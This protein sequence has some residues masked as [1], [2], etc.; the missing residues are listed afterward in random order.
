MYT[1]SI[2]D[3]DFKVQECRAMYRLACKLKANYVQRYLIVH[4]LLPNLCLS[5]CLFILDEAFSKISLPSIDESVRT[6]YEL[7]K[8]FCARRFHLLISHYEEVVKSL[9]PNLLK[10]LISKSLYFITGEKDLNRYMNLL[11]SR[12]VA[13]DMFHFCVQVSKQFKDAVSCHYQEVDLTE[14]LHAI[15]GQPVKFG[16][17]DGRKKVIGSPQVGNTSDLIMSMNKLTIDSKS[18]FENTHPTENRVSMRNEIVN[19]ECNLDITLQLEKNDFD[20][21]GVTF[22]S[23]IFHSFSATWNLKIDVHK[24]GVVSVFLIERSFVKPLEGIDRE[25]VVLNGQDIQSGNNSVRKLIDNGKNA[26]F[27]LNFKSV[28][29]S[30]SVVDQRFSKEFKIFHSFCKDQ[31]QIIGCCDFFNMTQLSSQEFIH[32]KVRISEEILHSAILHFL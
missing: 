9:D 7:T 10:F 18:E 24:S 17:M 22:F 2:N 20:R 19:K 8:L 29:F 32:F 12:G 14:V 27:P 1:S 6:L 4:K 26:T 30:V 31:N 15:G 25:V 13:E 11:M 16:L 28:L 23:E 3:V 21:E 5:N